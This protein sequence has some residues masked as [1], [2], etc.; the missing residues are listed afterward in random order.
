MTDEAHARE[1]DRDAG[2]DAAPARSTAGPGDGSAAAGSDTPG[3]ADD[4]TAAGGPASADPPAAAGALVAADGPASAGAP[5][6]EPD[7]I[8]AIRH[9]VMWNRLIS[10]VEEQAQALIRTAFSTSVREAGDLSAGVYDARARMLAQAVTGTPGHVNAMADAVAHFVRAIPEMREGD[11]YVTNDPWLGTGHL[12]DVTVVTPAFREGRLVGFLACTAHVVDV[13][14][15]GFGVDADSVYEEGLRLPI[16]HLAREGV[17]DPALLAI[18]RANVREP[19][20]VEGDVMALMTCNAVGARRLMGMMEEF[21]LSDLDGVAAHILG[22]S[23]RAVREAVA[24]LPD[25]EAEAHMAIDGHGRPVDLRVRLTV[26]G[27]AVSADFAGSS[28]VDP[29]GINVPLVY[30]K[31]YACYA[32]KCAIAPEVPNNAG[33]PRALRRH[34]A[35]GLDR[36]RTR[37]PRPWRCATSSGT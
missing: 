30:T 6:S 19:R 36:E 10:V 20:Q 24:G 9:Q 5:S 31:A 22:A 18:L 25:G 2:S 15:R 8:A 26:R 3:P 11:V 27:D 7:G 28:G 21:G 33:L 37:T 4:S 13:G 14:G 1:E 16:M 35:G 23:E 34:G 32:L 12:H 17:L 29:K